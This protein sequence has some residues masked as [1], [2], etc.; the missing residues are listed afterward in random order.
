VAAVLTAG[1]CLFLAAGVCLLAA[2]GARGRPYLPPGGHVFAGLTGGTSIVPFER[3]VAK[4]P[5]VFETYTTWDTRT[6]WLAGRDSAFRSR[7]GLHISTS[8]GY[9]RPGVVSPRGIARGRSDR[10][11]LALN[12]NLAH[13]RRIVYVRLMGEMNGYWNAY[14]AFSADGAGRGP[15]NTPRE[16]V[17]AWRRAVLIL[18][19]GSL[20]R[21]EV[22][23]RRLGLPAVRLRSRRVRELPRPKV[24]FL[25]V[26]QDAGSPDIQANAPAAFWPGGGYV[27]WI[28]TDFYASYPNFALLDRFYAEFPRKPFVLSEWALY[29]ADSPGFVRDLFGWVRRHHRVRMLNYYQGFVA[30]SRANLAHYPASRRTLR[31]ELRSRR[32]LAYPPEYAHP[33]RRHRHGHGSPVRPPLPPLVGLPPGPLPV[34]VLGPSPPPP[35]QIC[36]PLLKVCI[37]GL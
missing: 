25:W 11:L 18:R 13:S 23:L 35:P 31:S 17:A 29:G 21:I 2:A 36:L 33:G 22:R 26:P 10:F 30:S 12:R 8:P 1:L 6:G 9:G 16:F 14:A 5:P 32:F 15:Q 3:M 19:G 4:H 24:A 28:G 37:P 7:L 27:D 34:A 20:R